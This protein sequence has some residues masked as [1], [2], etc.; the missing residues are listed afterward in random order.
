MAK[1]QRAYFRLTAPEAKEVCVLGSFNN[2]EQ[3]A[4]KRQRNGVWTT[5]LMIEPGRYEYRFLVDGQWQNDPAA[6]ESTTN[7]YG[8]ENSILTVA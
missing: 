6:I 1:K 5:W 2:W 8:T 4:L 3:R 7:P